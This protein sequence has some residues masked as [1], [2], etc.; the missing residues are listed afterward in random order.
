MGH[1]CWRLSLRYIGSFNHCLE[2]SQKSYETIFF[3]STSCSVDYWV[4]SI[5]ACFLLVTSLF[6]AKSSGPVWDPFSAA[7]L[8]INSQDGTLLNLLGFHSWSTQPF[9]GTIPLWISNPL[10][11]SETLIVLVFAAFAILIRRNKLTL[12]LSGLLVIGIFLAQGTKGFFGEFY[13]WVTFYSP[14]II[15]NQA[16]LLKYPYLFLAIV[17]LA[18]A[19][20]IAVLIVEAF[21]RA[22]YTGFSVKRF[23]SRLKGFSSPKF[24]TRFS[25]KF[26]RFSPKFVKWFSL[27]PY[28]SAIVLFFLIMSVIAL[29]GAPLLTN[30]NGALNPVVLPPQYNNLNQYLTSQGGSF[31]VM[32][33]PQLADFT[34]SI[35]QNQSLANKIEYWASGVPPLMYGW[36]I[37]PSPDSSFLGNMIYDYLTGYLNSNQLYLG[38]L[39]AV[40][41][42]K[43]IVFHFDTPESKSYPSVEK[44]PMYL[45][46]TSQKDLKPVFPEG[47]KDNLYTFENMDMSDYFQ[48]FSK[49]NLVV[50]GLDTLGS[51]SSINSL[52]PAESAY[53]FL[54]NQPISNDT[55]TSILTANGI[56]KTLIFYGNKTFNDLVLDTID[57]SALLAPGDSFSNTA[58]PYGLNDVNDTTHYFTPET[59]SWTKDS[60][61][62][63]LWAP[64]TLPSLF[65]AS[66]PLL[67]VTNMTSDLAIALSTHPILIPRLLLI[68][69]L[70]LQDNTIFGLECYLVKAEEI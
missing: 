54:E 10:W 30:L 50:G 51:L 6:N 53:L 46:L 65:N 62:S 18:T 38:K 19:L 23:S 24:M 15:P 31:R 57:S 12:T 69:K 60:V 45:N 1:D 39:L 48:T 66:S 16:F 47:N 29:V 68:L 25:L 63:F 5:I 13:L 22:K 41:N 9:L 56:E 17:D 58:I 33:V 59:S 52:N 43:Y 42:V 14:R 26:K 27:K 20:L 44:D 32:W 11:I 55:L 67:Q 36:G 64:T 49:V 61:T 70:T 8:F 4:G 40:A 34:W 7:N 35:S 37:S 21:G 3:K 28:T 2:F